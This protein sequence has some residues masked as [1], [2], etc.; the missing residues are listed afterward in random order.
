MKRIVHGWNIVGIAFGAPNT[1]I[2]PMID[3]L[4]TQRMNRIERPVTRYRDSVGQYIHRLDWVRF[5]YYDGNRCAVAGGE[6]PVM[7][8]NGEL[9]VIQIGP[10][11]VSSTPIAG[12]AEA[13]RNG[14]GMD[15]WVEGWVDV[16]D[17]PRQSWSAFKHTGDRPG[18]GKH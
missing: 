10:Y 7:T 16:V 8:H 11:G 15:W 2:D 1:A 12:I 17:A 6:G 14:H 9:E 4:D 18:W 13:V 5:V 3:H